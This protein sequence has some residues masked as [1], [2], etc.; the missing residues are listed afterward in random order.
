MKKGAR[1]V[2]R[3]ARG[4]YT[5][6]WMRINKDTVPKIF[7]RVAKKHPNKVALYYEDEAWTFQ[8]LEDFSNKVANYFIACGYKKGD[9]VALLLDNR[10]EYPGIWLGLSKAGI[11]TAL[12]N[13]NLKSGPLHHSISAADCRAIIFGSDFVDAIEGIKSKLDGFEFFHFPTSET[14]NTVAGAI[15]LKNQIRNQSVASPSEHISQTDTNDT[16]ILMY[17]SG[18]T[19]LPKAARVTHSRYIMATT[20]VNVLPNLNKNDIFYNPLPLYHGN[21]GIVGVGQSLCFGITVVIRKKFSASNFWTDCKKYKC[22]VGNY[23]G[24]ICRYLLLTHRNGKTVEH[25]VKKMI[26]NGLRK[27]IWVDFMNTF[28]IP[29]IYEFYGATEGNA[30]LINIDNKVGAIGFIPALSRFVY[31]VAIIKCDEATKE[32]LRNSDGFCIRCEDGEAGILLGKINS[33]NVVSDFT[34]YT[35]KKETSKKIMRDVFKKGDSYFNSGDLMM[36]DELGYVYFKDRMGDTF[37]WKGENVATTEVETVASEIIGAKDVVVYGVE[38]PGSEGKAGM[39]AIADPEGNLDV[40]AL[41]K[42]L[43]SHLPAYAVPMFLRI[44]DSLPVT[45][46]FKV[47]K[48]ELQ[49]DGFDLETIRD[50]LY[51]LDAKKGVYIPLEHVYENIISQKLK[52]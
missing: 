5:L 9:N 11:V 20:G 31:P 40:E 43:K 15:D 7:T 24:E 26:G 13:T 3:G 46:T 51:F 1:A 28:N 37:R 8:Q 2:Y 41:A 47:K 39:I 50:A 34:G 12:L 21:G 33:A 49:K 17:T 27:E 30:S 36:R 42:G 18:T 23:I 45:G 25:G 14:C 4:V 38:V 48:M 10:P 29:E 32:P 22:T 52:L 6:M 16:I 44:L 35:D 19:G